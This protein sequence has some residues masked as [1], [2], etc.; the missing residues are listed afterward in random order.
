[1]RGTGDDAI[2]INSV[3]FN[4]ATHYTPMANATIE[5]NTSIAPWG[6][7]GVAIYGGSGHVV[8]N[9]YISDT[10]RYIGLGVGKFGANGSNLVSATVTGNHRPP[11]PRRHRHRPAELRG[12]DGLGDAARQRGHRPRRRQAALRQSVAG[13]HRHAR[14]QPLV[15]GVC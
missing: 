2:A 8:R 14:R 4:G 1:V 3:D 13:L 12:A 11:R 6:G 10:A 7:K 5:N 15:T 9:N